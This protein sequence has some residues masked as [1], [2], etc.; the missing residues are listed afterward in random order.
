VSNAWFT[1]I[2]EVLFGESRGPRFG[3][4][5]EMYGVE[6]TRALIAQG[7]KGELVR[8]VVPDLAAP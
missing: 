5:V 1:A 8:Q 4:F 6:G 2:Y 7:V 3:S